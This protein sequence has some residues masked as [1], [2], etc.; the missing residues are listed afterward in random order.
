MSFMEKK[1]KVKF[2][3]ITEIFGGISSLG[4]CVVTGPFQDRSPACQGPNGVCIPNQKPVEYD[5][6]MVFDRQQC[7]GLILNV[8][9][10]R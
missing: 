1:A 6:D 4:Q 3:K 10:P 7:E 8:K 2:S 5:E 9:S